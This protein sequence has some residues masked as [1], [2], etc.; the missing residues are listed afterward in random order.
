MKA[1]PA[2]LHS[3]HSMRARRQPR[4][5]LG[6]GDT[7]G[8]HC[9]NGCIARARKIAPLPQFYIGPAVL[10]QPR[11]PRP[12]AFSISSL[13]KVV[14]AAEAAPAEP[15][16]AAAAAASGGDPAPAPGEEEQA[17]LQQRYGTTGFAKAS[18]FAKT[19]CER[20]RHRCCPLCTDAAVCRPCACRFFCPLTTCCCL[21][22]SA[23]RH[24]CEPAAGSWG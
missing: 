10:T 22:A 15:A 2:A 7:S 1:I 3:C 5:L 17:L 14:M 16:G 19:T 6:G 11:A 21:P 9:D 20:G 13:Q 8:R 23:C 24:V 12:A 18:A 4:G